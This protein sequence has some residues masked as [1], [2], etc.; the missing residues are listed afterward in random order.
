MQ[1]D[2]KQLQEYEPSFTNLKNDK[3]MMLVFDKSGE[4]LKLSDFEWEM[5]IAF[6][7][8]GKPVIPVWLDLIYQ[9]LEAK[10][11]GRGSG[12]K[13]NTYEHT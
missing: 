11:N 6:L 9:Q 8:M 3:R 12:S 13:P 1:Q 10:L 5:A 7:D 4:L 2:L